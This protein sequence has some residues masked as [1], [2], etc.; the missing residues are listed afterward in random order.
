MDRAAVEGKCSES[1]GSGS[2]SGSADWKLTPTVST[3]EASNGG[4]YIE[5]GCGTC[6][7]YAMARCSGG[8]ACAVGD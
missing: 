2:A 7:A 6:S 5:G 3:V 8:S 4:R 1:L